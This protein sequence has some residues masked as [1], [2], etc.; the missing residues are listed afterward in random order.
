MQRDGTGAIGNHERG[1]HAALT[2]TPEIASLPKP[3][4]AA[5][6]WSPALFS[7]TVECNASR[8]RMHRL[9]QRLPVPLRTVEGTQVTSAASA[10]DDLAP[11]RHPKDG[12][13]WGHLD[14]SS[15]AQAALANSC[16]DLPTN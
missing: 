3:H 5:S 13:R 6:P 7:N 14:S 15:A 16:P 10:E 9:L 12:I 1:L 4:S 2:L 8:D 11:E